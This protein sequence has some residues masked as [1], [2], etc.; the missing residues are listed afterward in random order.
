ME[1]TFKK[2]TV[3][4]RGVGVYRDGKGGTLYVSSKTMFGGFPENLTVQFE[5]DPAHAKELEAQAG[6]AAAKEAAK[7]AKEE[8]K[9]AREKA[10]KAIEEAKAK[11]AAD[12]AA[13]AG[14][15]AQPAQ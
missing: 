8:L 4:G 10:K 7:K 9:A 3:S 11:I 15:P 2:E 12:A 6:K 5:P 13:N 14:Q 1:K